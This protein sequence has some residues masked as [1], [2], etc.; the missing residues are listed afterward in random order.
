MIMIFSNNYQLTSK[1]ARARAR[2]QPTAD[3]THTHT[4]ARG[5]SGKKKERKKEKKKREA[6]NY[7]R[8]SL[9]LY[10]NVV[11][12]TGSLPVETQPRGTGK[13]INTHGPRVI[14]KRKQWPGEE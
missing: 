11:Y 5:E 8:S 6:L 4:H 1:R 9:A 14:K 2:V 3:K 10:L 12:D 13:L 7:R